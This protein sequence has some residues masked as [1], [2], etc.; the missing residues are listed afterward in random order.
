[1]R[2]TY[3]GWLAV[4]A[5]LAAHAEAQTASPAAQLGQALP[6]LFP[7]GTLVD[8]AAAGEQGARIAR[9]TDAL[10]SLGFAPD[11]V[12]LAV[13]GQSILGVPPSMPTAPRAF[14]VLR[15]LPGQR[16][17]L[18]PEVVARAVL[19]DFA[20]L[21]GD[22]RTPMR[23]ARMLANQQVLLQEGVGVLLLPQAANQDERLWLELAN[24]LPQRWEIALQDLLEAVRKRVQLPMKETEADA[25]A[26]ALSEGD[27]LEAVERSSRAL[28]EYVAQPSQR[29]ARPAFDARLQVYREATR[30]LGRQEAEMLR[31]DPAFG[32]FVELQVN[33]VQ[34]SLPQRTLIE[35]DGSTGSSFAVGGRAGSNVLGLEVLLSYG[36][37]RNTFKGPGDVDKIKTTLHSLTLELAY[38]PRLRSFL[39]PTLRGGVGLYPLHVRILDQE[40]Q[41]VEATTRTRLGFV[42]GGGVDVFYWRRARIR[43]MLSGTY[44]IV[45]FRFAPESVPGW[46]GSG[47]NLGPDRLKRDPSLP[48]DPTDTDKILFLENERFELDLNG[49]Q[50]GLTLTWSF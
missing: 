9:V 22:L 18:P 44:R 5:L 49:W 43:G 1:M 6:G 30:Q 20:A 29:S 19:R 7:P 50:T 37:A 2:R 17:V 27:Y 42:V 24:P 33:N 40:E 15:R 3:A 23:L 14:T 16:P 31:A 38:R 11:D 48:G 41:Q 36:Q 32:I 21:E 10:A 35:A 28:L 34:E 12:V 45:S 26:Q 4:V 13:D 39:K 25:A 47:T 46:L 8:A